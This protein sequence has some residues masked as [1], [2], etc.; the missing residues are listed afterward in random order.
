MTRSEGNVIYEI[1]GKSAV[2]V[3]QEYLPDSDLAEDWRRYAISCVLCFRAPS[4]IKDE[5]Y[6]VRTI[7]SLDATDGSAIVQT[8]V[9][10]GTSVW[11]TSKDQEKFTAGLDRMAEQIKKGLGGNQPKSL[12]G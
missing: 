6:V 5:E 3:L 7:L 10:E 11:M 4:Y 1:D 2:E 8:E 9:Q 12:R